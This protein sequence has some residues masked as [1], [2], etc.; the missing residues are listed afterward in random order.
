[1]YRSAGGK[2]HREERDADAPDTDPD[3]RAGRD[4]PTE[5]ETADPAVHIDTVAD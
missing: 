3:C 2:R 4:E 5:E 1:L